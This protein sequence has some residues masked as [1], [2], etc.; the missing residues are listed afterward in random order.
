M[1]F[2]TSCG[3]EIPAGA[4]FCADCGNPQNDESIHCP[5]CGKAL[6]KN[7]KFCSGCGTPV[8]AE[9][10]KSEAK[11][12]NSK[13]AEKDGKFTKEGRKIIEAGPKP[14]HNRQ[15]Y[16]PPSQYTPPKKKKKGCRGCAIATILILAVLIVGTMLLYN[17]V[18]DWWQEFKTEQGLNELDTEGIEGIVDIEP[19]DESHLPENR[20]K[21]PKQTQIES[22][23]E[24]ADIRKA[25]KTVEDAFTKADTTQLKLL[26]TESALVSYSGAFKEM[27]PYM[28]ELGE[29]FK[30]RKLITATDIYQIYE[31]VD[32]KG[33]KYTAAFEL[34]PDGNWKLTRF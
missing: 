1:A 23:N 31:F 34:Q 14:G 28:Q 7:E 2:C 21:E 3:N 18:S 6:E 26:L 15:T 11:T 32:D 9:P 27:Q 5:S 13:P 29:A 4:K 19:G 25:A 17:R 30:N 10:I 20:N 12:V 24:D 22:I 8:A 33:E 16:T